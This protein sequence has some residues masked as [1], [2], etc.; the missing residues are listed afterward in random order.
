MEEERE[1]L[2]VKNEDPKEGEPEIF[3]NEIVKENFMLQH[4]YL[5]L[6]KEIEEKSKLME[7]QLAAKDGTTA[8][9]EAQIAGDIEKQEKNVAEQ[10][11]LYKQQTE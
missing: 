1:A 7:T 5:E 8:Q 9:M 4:K 3:E 11:E 10:T 2:K 6:M